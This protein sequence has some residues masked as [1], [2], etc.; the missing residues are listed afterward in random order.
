MKWLYELVSKAMMV[1]REAWMG[2]FLPG[3]NANLEFM[4]TVSQTSQGK[5][6]QSQCMF[7]CRGSHAGI[8]GSQEIWACLLNPSWWNMLTGDSEQVVSPVRTSPILA[9]KIMTPAWWVTVWICEMI[10]TWSLVHVRSQAALP[11]PCCLVWAFYV[12]PFQKLLCVFL[13]GNCLI[14]QQKVSV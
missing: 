14:Q 3:R 2:L 9:W 13:H 6:I 11:I 1:H 5:K 7:P 10:L 12:Y 4:I 8:R